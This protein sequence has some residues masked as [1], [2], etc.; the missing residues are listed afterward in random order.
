[1]SADQLSTEQP[2]TSTRAARKAAC[3]N[4]ATAEQVEITLPACP[5]CDCLDYRKVRT[6]PNGDGSRTRKVICK[7]CKSPYKI[8]VELPVSGSL[9]IH[10]AKL[11]L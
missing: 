2:K 11:P 4:W 7:G 3:I 10:P 8:V 9:E 1:M 5:N 6:D